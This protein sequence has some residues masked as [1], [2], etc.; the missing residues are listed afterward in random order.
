MKRTLALLGLL[1]G[2][3][4]G[5]AAAQTSVRLSVGFGD[6]YLSGFVVVGSPS[7]YDYPAYVHPVYVRERR[8]W[9]VRRYEFDRWNHDR[10]WHRGWYKRDRDDWRGDRDGRR[11]DRDDWRRD[12][13]GGGRDREDR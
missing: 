9:V 1:L 5:S 6:P 11:M 8:L 4:V 2:F 7:Y 10:G 12:R 3:T 13:D